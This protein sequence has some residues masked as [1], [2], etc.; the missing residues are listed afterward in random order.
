MDALEMA[1]AAA[2]EVIGS[3]EL[4]DMLPG[5]GEDDYIVGYLTKEIK[6][7]FKEVRR[8]TPKRSPK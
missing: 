7:K 1:E 2:L 5:N 8:A 3:D 6:A 4:Y